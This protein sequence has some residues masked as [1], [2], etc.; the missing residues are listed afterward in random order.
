[1]TS[2][3]LSPSGRVSERPAGAARQDSR[4]LHMHPNYR[5]GRFRASTISGDLSDPSLPTPP[6][7]ALSREPTLAAASPGGKVPPKADI[8]GSGLGY[9]VYAFTAAV[10]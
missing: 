8:K 2:K 5:S 4:A 7:I 6:V 1:M 3:R 9:L 10:V